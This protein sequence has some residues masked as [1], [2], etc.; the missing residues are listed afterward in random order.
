MSL[1]AN[2]LGEGEDETD[3][4]VWTKEREES[5]QHLI[6][7]CVRLLLPKSESKVYLGGWALICCDSR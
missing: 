4:G 3:L 7:H 2:R 1:L 5:V 6:Q